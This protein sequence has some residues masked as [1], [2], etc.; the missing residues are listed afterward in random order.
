MDNNDEIMRDQSFTP[1]DPSSPEARLHASRNFSRMGLSIFE[2][3]LVGTAIQVLIVT[4]INMLAPSFMENPLSLWIYTFVPLYIIA[5]PIGIKML[6]R[7]DAYPPKK[8][9]VGFIRFLA[10]AFISIFMMYAGNLIGTLITTAL[11]GGETVNPLDALISNDS[12]ILRFLIVVVVGPLMEEI[13]FRKLLI[14]RMNIYGERLAIVTSALLFGLFHGNLSQFF[15]AFL[16][17]IVWAYVYTRTG[18]LGYSYVLHMC[19]NFLGSIVAPTIVNGIDIEQLEA[20]SSTTDPE[21]ILNLMTPGIAVYIIYIMAVISA[22][23]AG[24]IIL[25][26]VRKRLVFEPAALELPKEGRFRTVWMNPGMLACLIGCIA[27]MIY[28]Q[29]AMSLV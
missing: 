26:V 21:A 2:I 1:V 28:S 6:M 3:L 19:V 10:A 12:F 13:I 7:V 22:A 15:Y 24:L 14:D 16:L 5:M 8:S 25:L 23:F 4:L 29:V 18:K 27:M 11:N 17:G 20:L 9:S